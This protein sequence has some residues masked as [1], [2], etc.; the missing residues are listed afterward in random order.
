MSDKLPKFV[1]PCGKRFKVKMVHLDTDEFG[2]TVGAEK[3]I[4]INT[5]PRKTKSQWE[6]L[7]HEM[8]H[9]VLYSTGI[10]HALPH[11][12]GVDIEE[13]LVVAL[14]EHLFPYIDLD[15]LGVRPK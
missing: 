6:T 5:D 9:A 15:K 7:V 8:I 3:I 11:E 4:K 1:Y 2:E 13:A 14:E 10:T 12:N